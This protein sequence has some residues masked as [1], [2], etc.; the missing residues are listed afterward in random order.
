MAAITSAQAGLWS[1]TTTW[2]GGVLPAAGDTVTITHTVTMD[3]NETD[4]TKCYGR[5]SINTGGTLIHDSTKATCFCIQGYLYINGGRYEQGPGST[6]KFKATSNSSSSEG[7]GLSGIYAVGSISNTQLVLNGS[8][9]MPE[10]TLT[11]NA[12][13]GDHILR[14][15]N[16][17]QFAIGEYISV[18]YD[19]TNDTVNTWNWMGRNMSDEGFIIHNIV[20][21]DM[22][23]RQ[24]VGIQDS[25]MATMPIG[26]NWA[27]VGNARKWQKD[28][29][30]YIDNEVFIVASVD[31]TQNKVTFTTSA[32]VQHNAGALMYETG[33]QKMYIHDYLQ[34]NL[35]PNASYASVFNAAQFTVG[36]QVK[37]D[38]EI[39]TISSVDIPNKRIY[40]TPKPTKDHSYARLIT[41]VGDVSH[42]TGNK[43]YKIATVT[44]AN[45]AINA[46]TIT[47]ANASML[48]VNDRIVIE[49]IAKVVNPGANG[50]HETT[51]TAVNG[52]TL[53]LATAIPYAT[54]I[55]FIVTKTNRDCVVTTTNPT[56]TQN[57]TWIYYTSGSTSYS[58]RKMI[59]RY[60]EIS[61]VGSYT[62]T[63]AGVCLRSDFNRLDCEGETRGIVVRDGWS[64]GGSGLWLYS[65]HYMHARNN[66]IVKCQTGVYPY[67]QNGSGIY[68]NITIG[69]YDYSYQIVSP[70]FYNQFQ[71]NIGMNTRYATIYASDS[72]A[73]YP[74]M[75]NIFKHH[76][77]GLYFALS[78][79]GGQYGTWIKNRY[80]DTS[81]RQGLVEGTRI[82]VQDNEF[83]EPAGGS[84]LTNWGSS[85]ANYD[86]RGLVGGML[87]VVN[88]NMIRSNFEMH[89]YGGIIEKDEVDHMGNGWSYKYI[90]NH[91]SVD[92]RISQ[93]V[94]VK[95]N[96]P[97]KIVAY[98]KKSSTYNGIH[99]PGI[100]VKGQY[101]TRLFQQMENINDRWMRVELSFIPIRSEMIEI[102]VGGRGTAGNFWIDPRVVVTTHDLDLIQGPYSVNLMF[103]LDQLS[104]GNPNI[105]LGNGVYL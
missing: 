77:R 68:N 83:I 51:I 34:A 90:P 52:N 30:L 3:L 46:T 26:Q 47:V 12:V 39:L 101:Q 2:T 42:A 98:M 103:G 14:V 50:G 15:T 53:T 100:V 64:L 60:V 79:V 29:K 27:V 37:I 28:I 61:H 1:A 7:T 13:I 31:E 89:S 16:A 72:N 56:D 59:L 40:F 74:E 32:A 86:E 69:N 71:Y 99:L 97:V 91:S 78:C 94:Y 43:V 23:V 76:E 96:I 63:Y 10:T 41:V 62:D 24:R 58:N 93:M 105:M 82:I 44:T 49:G 85:S 6:I 33:M 19:A 9:P 45:T 70:N 67:S 18:Y 5:V 38:D 65:Y 48:N 8:V 81:Y 4:G 22:Y 75:H 88:K 55:G 87:V 66:V 80:E 35:A 102:G 20:G 36:S 54:T 104:Q 25:I 73:I 84:S 11:S 17:S 57:R 21:N 92:L 95:Y